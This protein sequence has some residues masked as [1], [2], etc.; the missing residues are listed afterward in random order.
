MSIKQQEKA[1]QEP[2]KGENPE[3]SDKEALFDAKSE[4]S[5]GNIFDVCDKL[6]EIFTDIFF[7]KYSL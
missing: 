7:L 6:I 3:I 4:V 5:S 1:E 2:E